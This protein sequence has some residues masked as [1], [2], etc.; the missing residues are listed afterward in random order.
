MGFYVN[1]DYNGESQE[2][3]ILLMYV[4]VYALHLIVFAHSMY[5]VVIQVFL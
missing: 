5:S 1:D 2:G 4:F 3:M